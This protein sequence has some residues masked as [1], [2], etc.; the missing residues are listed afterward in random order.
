[1]SQTPE[2]LPAFEDGAYVVADVTYKQWHDRP[3]EKLKVVRECKSREIFMV[4]QSL[5]HDID[6]DYEY[7]FTPLGA[8]YPAYDYADDISDLVY[9]VVAMIDLSDLTM[10]RFDTPYIIKERRQVR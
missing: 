5:S 3:Y 10:N 6:V 8:E 7:T 1:M 4:S 2:Y 9:T